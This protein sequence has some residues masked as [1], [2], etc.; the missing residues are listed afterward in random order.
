MSRIG[1]QPVPIPINV[2]V[3]LEGRTVQVKGPKGE[4][5]RTL[6]EGVAI[7]RHG[8][9]LVITPTSANRVT[10]MRHGLSRTLV[11]NMVE[12]VTKGYS[13]T[14]E[15]V[16]VGY[17]AQVR[18]KTLVL[19]SGYSHPV[20]LV[21]PQGILYAVENNTKITVSG[22]EKEVVGNEAAK[23]RAVSP[24]EPY[25]GKGIKYVGETIL[26]K[27]GKAGKK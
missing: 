21:P 6:P 13:K 1:K 7:D 5:R 22:T 4:L 25:K 27:A 10:R 26:R 14:L 11:A 24:P 19:S 9:T 8:E 20:E 2:Q 15:M 12:G 23:I 18:G 17:R 16:G 3:Q